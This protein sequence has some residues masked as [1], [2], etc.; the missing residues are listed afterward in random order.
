MSLSDPSPGGNLVRRY[1][2]YEDTL[3][4][5]SR[6]HNTPVATTKERLVPTK[7]ELIRVRVTADE[8]QRIEDS[9]KRAGMSLSAY[10]RDRALSDRV[11]D[12]P[13]ARRF[14]QTAPVT[15]KA[16]VE[17]DTVKPTGCPRATMHRPNT[18]CKFC[19]RMT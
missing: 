13:D 5:H 12:L 17:Q 8:K 15:T 2:S 19:H 4:A 11:P 16:D 6:S 7:T 10:L 3:V 1:T 9:A 14:A 18:F